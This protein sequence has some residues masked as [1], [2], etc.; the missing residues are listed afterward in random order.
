MNKPTLRYGICLMVL[1]SIC[2]SFGQLLWKIATINET[3]ILLVAGFALYGLGALFMISAYHFGP[4]SA[5]QPILGLNYVLSMLL[6]VFVLGE[7]MNLL[8][9]IAVFLIV[10]GV[11]FIATGEK[12]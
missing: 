7:H 12:S 4:L 3:L 6:A 1:S 9:C 8:K 5:L 2:A 10:L 11:V